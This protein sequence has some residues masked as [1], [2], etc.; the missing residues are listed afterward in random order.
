MMLAEQSPVKATR[1]A[2]LGWGSL[3]WDRDASFERQHG[4]WS[5]DGPDLKLEFS[6]IS[7]TR[8]GALT[9]VIDDDH[10]TLTTVAWCLSERS[11]LDDAMCDLRCREGTTLGNIGQ[12]IVSPGAE[13]GSSSTVSGRQIDAWA[14]AR[15]LD[16]VVWT[17]LSSN[18]ERKTKRPFT[19]EAAVSYIKDLDPAAKAKAAEY[20]W[21]AP[22]FVKTGLRS[23][24]EAGA[25]FGGLRS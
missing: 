21:R 11:A 5:Y 9:L 1:I 13:Q 6:R 4:P 22:R 24:L 19:V 18:F 14:R 15:G 2:I 12:I 3:L 20:I 17:A 10:G 23:A 8:A 25:W 7:A 16:A